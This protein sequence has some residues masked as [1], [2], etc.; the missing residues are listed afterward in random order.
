MNG[1]SG[2]QST[3]THPGGTGGTTSTG[4][5]S[6]GGTTGGG[7]AGGTTTTTTTTS[8]TLTGPTVTCKYPNIGECDPG[9]VCC[10][11]R[12]VAS[13]IC[14]LAGNCDPPADYIEVKCDQNEDCGAGKSCCAYYVQDGLDLKLEKMYCDTECSILDNETPACHDD[15]DCTPLSCLPIFGPDYPDSKFCL[16]P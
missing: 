15:S 10:Y 5:S 14:K 4:G 3:A 6:T 1:G 9:Q 2:G 8:T 11:A 7:G 13:D 16:T 12:T